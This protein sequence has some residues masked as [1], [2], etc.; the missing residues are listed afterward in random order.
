[1]QYYKNK[2]KSA[3]VAGSEGVDVMHRVER[4]W[5]NSESKNALATMISQCGPVGRG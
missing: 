2:K 3:S 5:K 1:M 4:I